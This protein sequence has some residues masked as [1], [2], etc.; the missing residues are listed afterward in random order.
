MV[1]EFFVNECGPNHHS[2]TLFSL[3]CQFSS[4]RETTTHTRVVAK[5][6]CQIGDP[7][8]DKTGVQGSRIVKMWG[9]PRFGRLAPD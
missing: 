8:E 9:F 4:Q 1:G 2:R 7:R 3:D 6:W 5:V